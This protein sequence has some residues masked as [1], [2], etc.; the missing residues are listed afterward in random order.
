MKTTKNL[1]QPA[2]KIAVIVAAL[3]FSSGIFAQKSFNQFEGKNI[4]QKL[5]RTSSDILA[6]IATSFRTDVF[7]EEQISLEDWMIDL[8]KFAKD[9]KNTA[10]AE[11]IETPQFEE[12]KIQIEDWMMVSDWNYIKNEHFKEDTLKLEKWMCCPR[13][14]IL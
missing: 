7:I 14:W 4:S 12:P 11:N 8:E 1:P 5:I 10:T 9:Y 13:N 3:L 6:D 2:I